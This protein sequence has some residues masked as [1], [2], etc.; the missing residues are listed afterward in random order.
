MNYIHVV[1]ITCSDLNESSEVA[2]DV[3]LQCTNEFKLDTLCYFT[4]PDGKRLDKS[5]ELSCTD[6][7]E[8]GVGEWSEDLPSCICEESNL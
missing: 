5:V 7:D 6:A 2:D 4:C 1:D 3:T 8:D